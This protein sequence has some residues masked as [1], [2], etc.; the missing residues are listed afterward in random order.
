MNQLLSK[1]LQRSVMSLF[2]RLLRLKDCICQSAE[3][4]SVAIDRRRQDETD[5]VFF[6]FYGLIEKE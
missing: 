1:C 2:D 6:A 4:E 5:I 3:I